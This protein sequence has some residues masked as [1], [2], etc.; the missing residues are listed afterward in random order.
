MFE[1]G[2]GNSTVK[3]DSAFAC[4]RVCDDYQNAPAETKVLTE[5]L[6]YYFLQHYGLSEAEVRTLLYYIGYY[7]I[8]H[9]IL[10]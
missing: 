8:L 10:Y 9:R 6:Y 5:M 7:T 4:R 2:V 3:S 1:E